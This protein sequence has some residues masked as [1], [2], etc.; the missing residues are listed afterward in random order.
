MLHFIFFPS[1]FWAD[2][3]QVWTTTIH[4]KK[5]PTIHKIHS[6]CAIGDVCVYGV[7]G[8][9]VCR[10]KVLCPAFFYTHKTS[11][12]SHTHSM[13]VYVQTLICIYIYV[14]IYIYCGTAVSNYC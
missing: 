9:G 11:S 5:A 10:A 2:V 3:F 12:L 6:E 14:Y 13:K 1:S 4:K 8:A 7:Y